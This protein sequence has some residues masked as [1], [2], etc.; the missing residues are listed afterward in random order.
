V[1]TTGYHRKYAIGVLHG[2]RKRAKHPVRRP[3][4]AIYEDPEARALLLLSDLFEGIF[5]KHPRAAMDVE[6]PRLY[7]ARHLQ[8]ST[9]CY[10]KLMQ[11]SPATI[12]LLLAGR[13]PIVG[14][15]LGLTRPG[16][17]LKD[18][19]PVLS[20]P[21]V[22]EAPLV[23]LCVSQRA[24]CDRCRTRLYRDPVKTG[25]PAAVVCVQRTGA[26]FPFHLSSLVSVLR[27]YSKTRK[28]QW[29]K[30]VISSTTAPPN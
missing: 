1:K 25:V 28:A 19:I 3:R 10:H 30:I 22:S 27:Q 18:C 12:D 16:T 17:L 13:H 23:G 15:S 6:L 2:K 24:R 14:K 5:S 29:N 21:R 4:R 11:I 7:A 8:V 9:A 20:S 26:R